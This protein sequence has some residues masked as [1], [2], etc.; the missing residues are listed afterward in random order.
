MQ[1]FFTFNCSLAELR[2][3]HGNVSNTTYKETYWILPEEGFGEM[4]D[5]L[6]QHNHHHYRQFIPVSIPSTLYSVKR[7]ESNLIEQNRFFRTFSWVFL[8]NSTL[9]WVPA[10]G[11]CVFVALVITTKRANSS[12]WIYGKHAE[13]DVKFSQFFH[14]TI[15]IIEMWSL[16]PWFMALNSQ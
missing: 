15:I 11:Q 7:C 9:R 12:R 14:L 10:T 4:H 1:Y 16:R 6:G 8:A 5:K 3:V 2:G 13:I